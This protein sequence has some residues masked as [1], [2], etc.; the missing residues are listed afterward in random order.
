[1]EEGFYITAGLAAPTMNG[2]GNKYSSSGYFPPGPFQQVISGLSPTTKYYYQAFIYRSLGGFSYGIWQS[3]TTA[4]ASTPSTNSVPGVETGPTNTITDLTT[5]SVTLKGGLTNSGG[6][7]VTNLGFYLNTTANQP[8]GSGVKYSAPGSSYSTG[9]F[10]NTITG[11]SPGTTYYYR[12]FAQNSVGAGYGANEYSFSTVAKPGS[13]ISVTGTTSFTYSGSPQG[14]D[15]STVGGS[16]GTVSYSYSGTSG[17]TYGPNNT[18]PTMAGSYTVTATVAADAYYDAA[19]SSA[20]N[21]TIGKAALTLTGITAT[22]IPYGQTLSTSVVEGTARNAAGVQVYGQW[23]YQNSGTTPPV[24]TNAY[25][26]TF[27]PNDSANYNS[28][29]GTVSLTVTARVDFTY[30][31]NNGEV[32]ITG[33]TGTGGAVIIP[34]TIVGY[35]VTAIGDGAF[36]EKSSITSVTIP[37]SVTSIGNGAFRKCTGLT[38]LIIPDSVTSIAG[39]AFMECSGLTSATIPDSVTSIG[40]SAFKDCSN[41]TNVTIGTG[42]TSIGSFA[43]FGC[44]RLTNLSIPDGVQAIQNSTFERCY[45]LTNLTIGTGVTRIGEKALLDCSSL[46]SL[47]IPN[48][49]TSIEGSAFSGCTTLGS[50]AIGS[51][52]TNVGTNAFY[53]CR[54]LPNLTIPNNVT[55]I[56]ASAF[57]GCNGLTNL[58][59]G[60]GV[61]HIASSTFYACTNLPSVII[62]NT[63]TTVGTNAFYYC[64][65]LTN[66]T[67]GSGV[68]NISGNAFK[69]SSHLAAVNFLQSAPPAVASSSFS[70]VVSNAIGYYPA[71]YSGAWSNT[72]IAGLTLMPAVTPKLD[73]AITYT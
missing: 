55:S 48:N 61:T 45:G 9:P 34:R 44:S 67:I 12:A 43:F 69:N 16:G 53:N 5:T 37:D 21:F 68:T 18:K 73:Q 35:P 62:P 7:T 17:T 26:V 6:V 49:V 15:T 30:T 47:T 28:A 64:T 59:I 71:V 1:M 70:G 58:T 42:V 8:N 63:V 25:G 39:G 32:T 38:N 14:P 4:S 24:G 72:T 51:G 2:T 22:S 27:L 40:G 41:L 19:S 46:T 3:F 23:E 57:G 10:T 52:V 29:D 33:Y 54:G 31:I 36:L 11:L 20:V 65:S 60:S 56:G 13:T 66:L 50:L